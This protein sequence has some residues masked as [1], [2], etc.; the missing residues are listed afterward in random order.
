[1]DAGARH[2]LSLRQPWLDRAAVSGEPA[3]RRALC[4]GVA[5]EHRAGDGGRLRAG[6]RAARAGEPA[7]RARTGQRDGRAVHRA[8]KPRAADCHLRTAG[9]AP[10]LPRAVAVGRLG[11]HGAPRD[12]VGIRGQARRR[13]ARRAGAGVPLG[14]DAPARTRVRLDPDELLGRARRAAAPE[15]A[16]HARRTAGSG[17]GSRGTHGGAEARAGV[18]RGRWGRRRS[19][20]SGRPRGE[21]RLRGLPR[22]AERA[23]GLPHAATRCTKGC[24]C[25]PRRA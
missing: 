25:P 8:E 21:T 5:G 6:E 2:P 3:R 13:C 12:E 4:A 7:C 18:W 23:D 20:R 24:C 15:D 22:A 9:H 1:V 16:A 11:G 19:R 17:G 10:Y 14:D